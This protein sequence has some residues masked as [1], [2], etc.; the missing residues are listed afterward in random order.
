MIDKTEGKIELLLHAIINQVKLYLGILSNLF[1]RFRNYIMQ[2]KKNGD[3]N[4]LS[5]RA[6]D[7]IGH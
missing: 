5:H 1:K 4:H 6:F 3:S 7:N 2:H